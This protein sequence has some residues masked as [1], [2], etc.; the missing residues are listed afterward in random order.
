[1]RGD[2]GEIKFWNIQPIVDATGRAGDLMRRVEARLGTKNGADLLPAAE[3]IVG[4]SDGIKK[5]FYVT[6]NCIQG[7]AKCD[8]SGTN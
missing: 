6:K 3:L 2:D 1:M 4:G 7:V 8:D 5:D